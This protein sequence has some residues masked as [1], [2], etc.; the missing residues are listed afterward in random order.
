MPIENIDNALDEI[1]KLVER[2][3]DRFSIEPWSLIKQYRK[4]EL[5]FSLVFELSALAGHSS[6]YRAIF[7]AQEPTWPSSYPHRDAFMDHG[8]R[9]KRRDDRNEQDVFVA[10]VECMETPRGRD[11]LPC[12]A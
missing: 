3:N 8:H 6:K 4:A 2:A 1:N 11:S 10:D 12:T 9:G 5:E 7:H